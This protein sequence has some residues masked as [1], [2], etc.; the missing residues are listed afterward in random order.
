M[1]A[2]IKN[3]DTFR[4][5]YSILLVSKDAGR[6]AFLVAGLRDR[7]Q[8]TLNQVGSVDAARTILQ[9]SRID[10]VVIDDQLGDSSGL[11]FLREVSIAHPFVNTALV[12]NLSPEEFHETTEGFGVFMQIPPDPTGDTA[13]EFLQKLETIRKL[14]AA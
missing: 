3:D 11:T 4:H 14:V 1:N 7:D 5:L 6:L 8:L 2:T 9:E 13:T 10:A 12:S